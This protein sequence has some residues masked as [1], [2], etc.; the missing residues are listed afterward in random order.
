MRVT[1]EKRRTLLASVMGAVRFD[2]KSSFDAENVL[3]KLSDNPGR[4]AGHKIDVI[5]FG[6]AVFFSS[7]GCALTDI[8]D[9]ISLRATQGHKIN[10]IRL[11][12]YDLFPRS[13]D[14]AVLLLSCIELLL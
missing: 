11:Q 14:F 6:S 7:C 2:L 1:A 10:P 3:R 4:F 13:L 8:K 12:N 9:L 5:V